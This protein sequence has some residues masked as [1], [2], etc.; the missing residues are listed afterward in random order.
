MLC[1]ELDFINS[2]IMN[3]DIRVYGANNVAH[4]FSRSMKFPEWLQGF[5]SI[6]AKDFKI[7][8]YNYDDFSLGSNKPGCVK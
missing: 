1:I 6:T 2:K 4:C 7:N 8:R 3:D 5:D